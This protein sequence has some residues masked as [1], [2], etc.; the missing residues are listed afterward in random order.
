MIEVAAVL[1]LVIGL[2]LGIVVDDE[3]Y[4]VLGN[5]E[6]ILMIVLLLWHGRRI[7]KTIEPTVD[8]TATIV[9]RE[10]GQR[11]PGNQECRPH[12]GR[13]STDKDGH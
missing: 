9:R 12:T 4:R 11:N 13:R 2:P 1:V 8:E 5:A 10:L 3:L 7:R 6:N